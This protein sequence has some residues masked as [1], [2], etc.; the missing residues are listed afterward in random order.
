M[1]IFADERFAS[2]SSSTPASLTAATYAP[3]GLAK[4]S[5]ARIENRSSATTITYRFISDPTTTL[6]HTLLTG[7]TLELNGYDDIVNF[8]FLGLTNSNGILFVSYGN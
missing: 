8:K 5:Y 7:A 2:I 6:G 4:A 3:A 1:K